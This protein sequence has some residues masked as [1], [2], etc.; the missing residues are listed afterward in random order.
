MKS[1]LIIKPK[2]REIPIIFLYS[3]KVV[4]TLP[5]DDLIV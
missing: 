3:Y 2:A 4:K 5:E 1:K